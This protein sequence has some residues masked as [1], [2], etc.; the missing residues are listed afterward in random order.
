MDFVGRTL[1]IGK[2]GNRFQGEKYSKWSTLERQGGEVTQIKLFHQV[3]IENKT[4]FIPDSKLSLG[5]N[6]TGLWLPGFHQS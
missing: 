4:L 5:K 1:Y 2:I 3:Q 6:G